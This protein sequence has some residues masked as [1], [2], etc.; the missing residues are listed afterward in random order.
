MLELAEL[1]AELAEERSARVVREGKEEEREEM[2]RTVDYLLGVIERQQEMLIRDANVGSQAQKERIVEERIIEEDEDETIVGVNEEII[3][4][5]PNEQ[6]SGPA[7]YAS[8][9]FS[10]LP[11]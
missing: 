10:T 2:K 9:R 5:L 8:R 7:K 6:K 11:I 4:A 1:K 3:A